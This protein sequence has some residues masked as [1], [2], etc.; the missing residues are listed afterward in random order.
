MPCHF[1]IKKFC[2]NYIIAVFG[3]GLP[4]K[5]KTGTKPTHDRMKWHNLVTQDGMGFNFADFY[6]VFD[7]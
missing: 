2:I 6:M 7:K 4:L 3:F 5:L 1:H